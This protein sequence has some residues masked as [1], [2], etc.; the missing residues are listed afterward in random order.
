MGLLI[1]LLI[2]GAMLFAN[3]SLSNKADVLAKE[4]GILRKEFLSLMDSYMVA[5]GELENCAKILTD[6]EEIQ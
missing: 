6:I 2:M 4:N 5:V 3:M 1:L